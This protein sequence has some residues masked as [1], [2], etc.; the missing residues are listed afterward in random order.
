MESPKSS[1]FP[2]IIESQQNLENNPIIIGKELTY[3][4]QDLNTG[5]QVCH[6][7]LSYG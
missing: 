7:R 2:T 1:L 3:L 6:N 5:T 4:T